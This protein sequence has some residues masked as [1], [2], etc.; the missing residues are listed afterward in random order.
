MTKK[1]KRGA[2]SFSFDFLDS[3]DQLR[4]LI[5]QTFSNVFFYFISFFLRAFSK[6]NLLIA[7]SWTLE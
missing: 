7:L 1:K 2:L 5:F 4:L 3:K 6:K